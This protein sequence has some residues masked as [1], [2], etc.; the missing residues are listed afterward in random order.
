M[1]NR[2]IE[3]I[4]AMRG[5]T[6]IL[7]V[8]GHVLGCYHYDEFNSYTNLFKVFRMPLFFFISGWVLYKIDIIW[9][10]AFT[11]RFIKKKFLI[12]IIPTAIFMSIILFKSDTITWK[13][14]NYFKSGYWFTIALFEYFIFY[15]LFRLLSNYIKQNK[16]EDIVVLSSGFLVYLVYYYF[17]VPENDTSNKAKVINY[18]GIQQWCYYVFF[19]FGT[20][21]KKYYNLFIKASNKSYLITTVL[22]LFFGTNIFLKDI[23]FPLWNTIR[24]LLLGISGIL[25]VLTFF[26]VN[27]TSF[28][29]EKRIGYGLQ[30]IGKRTLDIYLLHY[31]FLPGN[32]SS[33]GCFLLKNGSPVIE[34]ILS[35]SLA[36]I[37][38]GVCLIISN[39]LRMSPFLS[40]V[41]FG[42]TPK[43]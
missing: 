2:R 3:Y 22:I 12:Q 17:L 28:S 18:I 38:I 9:D 20:I 27:E 42:V 30:Y 34:L 5:L 19:C 39:V 6:M 7:V 24:F 31:F 8:M 33:I 21:V 25:I 29:K 15:S 41:L 4:D 26:R 13:A 1:N 32:L 11:K 40:Q 14:F 43:K 10:F 37:V 36:L 35:L 16:Y 23:S